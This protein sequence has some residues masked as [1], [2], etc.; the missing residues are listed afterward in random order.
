MTEREVIAEL[1][2]EYW[3]LQRALD[4]VSRDL[5]AERLGKVAAQL[6]YSNRQLGH[7]LEEAGLKLV[8]FDDEEFSAGLPVSPINAEDMD[9]GQSSFVDSTVEPAIVANGTTIRTGK[10]ILRGA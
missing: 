10:V 1:A 7:L 4:R 6:R 8:T 3:K 9:G 2:T 5:P